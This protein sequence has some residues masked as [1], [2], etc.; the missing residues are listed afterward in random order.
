MASNS[1][2]AQDEGSTVQS[3]NNVNNVYEDVRSSPATEA[4][5]HAGRRPHD[6]I[7]TTDTTETATPGRLDDAGP[8]SHAL[9]VRSQSLA[10]EKWDG[11]S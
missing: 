5:D 3:H 2:S 7:P 6:G 9:P 10:A 11:Q 4:L 1:Q 8:A